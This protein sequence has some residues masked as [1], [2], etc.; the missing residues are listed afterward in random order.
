L[1]SI[2]KPVDSL[3]EIDLATCPVWE[4]DDEEQTHDECFVRPFANLPA[5]DLGGK[6]VAVRVSLANGQRVWA[7][8]GNV[9]TRNAK[10]TEHF[11]M[12]SVI[13]E[14]RWFSLA[15]YHDIDYEKHGPEALAAFLGLS[16]NEVFPISYD[17]SMYVDGNQESLVGLLLREPR[18]RLTM[19]E[20]I[21]MAIR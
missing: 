21:A 1:N 2:A 16:I 11:L 12:L 14:G 19:A 20:L 15:R 13:K 8:I 7:T 18:E 4:F 5:E 17:I 6:L 3:Q 10:S 9:D